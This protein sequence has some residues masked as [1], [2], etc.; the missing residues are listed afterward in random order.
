MLASSL[1]YETTLANVAQLV[2]P[3]VADWFTVDIIGEDG[4]LQLQTVA[5]ADPEKV[6]WA[7]ELRRQYPMDIGAAYGAPNVVRTGQPEL[8]PDIPDSLLQTVAKN[9]EEFNLLRSVG[10][11]SVMIV[12][13]QAR[14]RTVGALTLVTTE[15]NRHY[16]PADLDLAL[17]LARR[18]ALAIDNSWLY[19][20][21]I[22]AEEELRKTSQY[23]ENLFDYANAPIIVWDPDYKI[24]RF[25]HA[26]EHLTEYTADEVIGQKLHIL[27]PVES[28]EE[29]LDKIALT[30]A[31]Q[32]QYWESV[33]IP[34][35]R[36]DGSIRV[37]L[38]NSANLYSEDGETLLATIA[39]GQDI[40]E[41]R[42]AEEEVRGLNADLL[43][44]AAEIDAINK[45]LESF[46][47]S[48][49]HDLRAPLRSI[50]G[51]SQA[52]LEDYADK[53]DEQGKQYLQWVRTASQDMAELIDDLLTLSRINRGEM[54]REKV[55]LSGLARTI[56]AQLRK[57]QP[58]RQVDF[59]IAKGLTADGD[60]RL[61]RL[62]MENLLENAW[63]FTSKHQRARIEL[64]ACEHEG[65]PA[66][67]VRD[68]GAGFD[69]AYADKLF[70]AFQRLHSQSD[71]DGT[72]IG[73]ATVQRIIHR[74]GGQVWAE[75]EVEKG[76][77]F[78]FTL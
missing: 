35:L 11:R 57:G 7:T 38:W 39:Q 21:R 29:S 30:S 10:Y 9:A 75:G 36:K 3:Q 34:I 43:R 67:F 77:T 19:R 50:D 51:F 76:A 62:A 64:G 33:E 20:E 60:P 23:L 4:S 32:C 73:L 6:Q 2:V 14:G 31:G 54:R 40:T 24:T 71:F 65:K 27:F 15:S 69:M 55:D 8:Y 70:G 5:H 12:P 66:Y 56:A 46:S 49:S 28:R 72:G 16:G 63:K 17:E 22:E 78:C 61:L 53:L 1:D 41:R 44:R 18:V 26:F 52:L 58:E 68:D 59:V 37:A 25:N 74:H 13:L 42:R 47:Y 45:E 48:V